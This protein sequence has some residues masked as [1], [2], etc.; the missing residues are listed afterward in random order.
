[1]L[2]SYDVAD[3]LTAPSDS[4]FLEQGEET[5]AGEVSI[6]RSA[7]PSAALDV[8]DMEEEEIGTFEAHHT[9]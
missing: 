9:S 5:A 1:M 7:D 6:S 8:E 2:L 3:K 4:E